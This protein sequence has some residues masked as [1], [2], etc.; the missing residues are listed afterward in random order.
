MA[1]VPISDLDDPRLAVYRS[2]KLTN[3]TRRLGQFVVEG[4]KLVERLLASRFPAVSILVT[5]RHEPTFATRVPEPVPTYVVPRTLVD[6]L[7]GFPFHRGV[8]AC[9][10]HGPGRHWSRSL[11]PIC[12]RSLSSSAPG[13]PTRKTLEQSPGSATSS[14]STRS[15]PATHALIRSRAA[16]CESRWARYFGFR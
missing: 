16:S 5:D 4:E 6:Q 7:V 2:L 12:G 1:I 9:A 11:A 3:L 15:W 13:F 8:L 14:G 10:E